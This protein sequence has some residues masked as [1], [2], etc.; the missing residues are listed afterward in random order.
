MKKQPPKVI[1]GKT[2]KAK[3]NMFGTGVKVGLR[4][5]RNAAQK[6]SSPKGQADSYLDAYTKR[7]KRLGG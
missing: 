4:T 6:K 3:P 2:P 5:M 1:P 7:Q